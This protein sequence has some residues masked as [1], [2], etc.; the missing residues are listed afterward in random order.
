MVG[1]KS[2]GRAPTF[3]M[4][5]GYEQVRSVAAAIAGDMAAADAVQLVLPETGVCTV[6]TSF[7]GSSSGGCCGGP[8]PVAVDDCRVADP[9]AKE[10]GEGGGGGR[11]AGVAFV[12]EVGGARNGAGPG[13]R[14]RGFTPDEWDAFVEGA[15]DGEFDVGSHSRRV[16]RLIHSFS[17]TTPHGSRTPVRSAA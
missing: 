9:Q 8:A 14:I 12:G 15:K 5:T 2:Y 6:P 17:S 10:K 3:L 16:R 11:L 7:S 1:M 13:G 4:M